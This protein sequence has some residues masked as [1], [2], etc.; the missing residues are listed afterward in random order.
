[1]DQSEAAGLALS[2]TKRTWPV[3]ILAVLLACTVGE[4]PPQGPGVPPGEAPG[5]PA[6]ER[7]A[8]PG[9]PAE[10]AADEAER[11]A[12][13]LLASARMAYEAAE[14]GEALD[15][16]RA[17][18]RDY[19]GTASAVAASWLAARAAF[20]L[21][22]WAEA[23]EL[24]ES[25]A[26]AEPGS[27]AAADATALA[28]LARDELEPASTAPVRVGVVLPRTGSRVM[29]RYADWLLEGIEI[30]V[31]QAEARERRRIELVVADDAGG[32]RTREA[33]A[34]LEARGVLA[35]VGPLLPPQLPEIAGA[36]RD[37]A[38]VTISPTVPDHPVW[39]HVYTVN[40]GDGRGAQELGRYAAEVGIRQA[41]LLYPRGEEY[42]RKARAFAVEFEAMGGVV[43][44]AMPYDSGTTT[45]DVHM[46]RILERVAPV[47][48]LSGALGDSLGYG[49]V[50][51]T[52]PNAGGYGDAQGQAR[53]AQQPF[54]LF[55]AAPERDVRQIAPQ[56]AFYGLDSAGV[57]VFGDEAWASA[58]VR[59]VVPRQDIEGVIAASHF[60]PDR[61]DAIADPEFV[62]R[63][64]ETYRRSLENQL[65]ALGYDAANL[66]LQALPN[67]LTSPSALARRFGL[68][69][70]IRGAT[71]TFAIRANRV[72]RTPYMVIIRDGALAPAPSPWEY[73]LPQPKPAFGETGQAGVRR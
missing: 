59:R 23:V 73:T 19:P 61:A 11:A 28:E 36:R 6:A 1:M 52:F 27:G 20:S 44:A 25:F 62:R 7:P 17:A 48:T 38:L 37:G 39:P 13:E 8:D 10:P 14:L 9:V 58:A 49:G 43:R 18:M 40:T 15:L 67:R 53:P 31:R 45:F 54:A 24:A 66:V 29:V 5:D 35:V 3:V 41:A 50:R 60:P 21:H 63:Y 16:S 12:A 64:E 33:I 65:P 72:V 32:T 68:L 26:R 42:E 71:G 55:V 4:T 51:D 2:V 69:A 57:Q 47:D 34:E 56:V 22:R 30:A 46:Q 70:G